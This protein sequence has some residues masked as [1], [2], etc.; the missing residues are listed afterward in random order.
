MLWSC[1]SE[2]VYLCSHACLYDIARDNVRLPS[3][4]TSL[5]IG[6]ALYSCTLLQLDTSNLLPPKT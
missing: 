6:R 5:K 3:P 1:A 2:Y 4:N